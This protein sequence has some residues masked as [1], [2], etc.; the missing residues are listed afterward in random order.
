MFTPGMPGWPWPESPIAPEPAAEPRALNEMQIEDPDR[1][2]IVLVDIPAGS[3]SAVTA[4]GVTAGT[5]NRLPHDRAP[6]RNAA[7]QRLP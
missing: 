2:R 6:H 3:P 1:L 7:A 5:T 4:S